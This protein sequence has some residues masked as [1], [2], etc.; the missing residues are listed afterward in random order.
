MPIVVG[1]GPGET[2]R[3]P[4]PQLFAGGYFLFPGDVR[5]D[6]HAPCV[7]GPP[8]PA[9]G[10]R[11]ASYLL[12]LCCRYRRIQNELHNYFLLQN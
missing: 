2:P 3:Q 12:L 7:P 9:A 5:G 6:V 1:G 4:L 11:A 8:A 10:V